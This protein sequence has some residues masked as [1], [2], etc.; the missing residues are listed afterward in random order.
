[1]TKLILA[2]IFLLILM[3]SVVLMTTSEETNKEKT[4]MCKEIWFDY[5]DCTKKSCQKECSDKHD[6]DPH[7]IGECIAYPHCLCT[8]AC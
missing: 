4:T 7:A 2:N 3:T 8:Y 1:M 6:D 5:F